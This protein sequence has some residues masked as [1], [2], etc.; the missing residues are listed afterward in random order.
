MQ[1]QSEQTRLWINNTVKPF[2]TDLSSGNRL[3]FVFLL[4]SIL[5]SSW[6]CE[7]ELTDSRQ[8][9]QPAEKAGQSSPQQEKAQVDAD[10]SKVTKTTLQPARKGDLR[11]EADWPPET[12]GEY[13]IANYPNYK[14][15]GDLEAIREQG[16][17]RILVDV[18]NTDSLHRKLTELDIEL[19]EARR[20]AKNLG[21]TP[22]VLYADN[23]DELIPALVAG[24]GDLIANNVVNTEERRALVEFSIPI[25]ETRLSIVTRKDQ[26]KIKKPTDLKGKSLVVTRGTVYEKAARELV[27]N[28]PGIKLEVVDRSYHDLLRDLSLS[29]IDYTISETLVL[30]MV[31]Q[32]RENLKHNYVFPPRGQTGWVFRKQSPQLRDAVNEYIHQEKLTLSRKPSTDDLDQIRER[33]F[34]RAATRNQAG[35]YFMWKGRI[36]GFEYELLQHLAKEMDLRLDIQVAHTHEDLQNLLKEGQVDISA[37]L[38]SIT[39]RRMREG[40]IFGPKYLSS[41]VVLVSHGRDGQS[42]QDLQ[43]LAGKQV[44][45]L[46]SSNHYDI[47]VA[48][49]EKV[50]G[51]DIALVPENLNLHDILEKVSKGDYKY[52]IADELTVELELNEEANIRTVYTLQ[53][54]G[55]HYAWMMRE[56]NP[57]LQKVVT[58]FFN[59]RKNKDLIAKLHTKYFDTPP[60]T[61]KEILSLN[62]KGNISPFDNLVKKYSEEHNFDWRLVVAQMYQ[63]STFNPK[64]KSWVGARGLL[65]VMPDTGKQMGE[66]NLFDPENG[67]RA[68]IKY[69]KWLHNKFLDKGIS[70][71]NMMWFTLAAYNAGLGH[72]YDAQD[73]SEF[74]GWDRNVWFDNV[75]NAMLLL[76]DKKYYSK[77]RY[78]YARGHEP[79][80]YVRKIRARYQTYVQLLDAYERQQQISYIPGRGLAGLDYSFFVPKLPTLN[81]HSDMAARQLDFP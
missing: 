45:V 25:T 75:E 14:E 22:V 39:D 19:E 36:Q 12:T 47:A 44:H 49:Q 8:P 65:Q 53:D 37:S 1:V 78:G 41:R 42:V 40:M 27:A 56:N 11:R 9:S 58:N 74:K 69:L 59:N 61:R 80:D 52:A 67:V 21:L 16:K 10:T 34:L 46:K 76:S 57:K 5:C 29:K 54:K 26:P 3:F 4:L 2:S 28:N 13:P 60:K 48:L 38:L 7:K 18:S 32:Y 71:E 17:L 20:F 66:K 51:L 72:V 43:S 15:L 70:S 79:Y 30:S 81:S 24:K 50:P 73:L 62:R 68:G 31:E 6:G 55:N 63:E 35:S 33:G 23:F 77:A 64:A